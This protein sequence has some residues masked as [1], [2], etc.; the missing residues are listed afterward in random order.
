[1]WVT[2]CGMWVTLCGMWVTLCGMWVTLCGM[3]VTPRLLPGLQ[4]LDMHGL[5][6]C[7]HFLASWK[8]S[9]SPHS[10]LA[11]FTN[12]ARLLCSR[13]II[14]MMLSSRGFW[15]TLALPDSLHVAEQGDA[16]Q[17]CKLPAS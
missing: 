6:R 9:S 17:F 11:A 3:W 15:M 10:G 16:G 1:M 13:T 2:R 14:V 12:R 4:N 7:T 8:T 5:I